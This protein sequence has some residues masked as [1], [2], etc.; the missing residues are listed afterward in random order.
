[1]KNL[2]N[3]YSVEDLD[4]LPI[5]LLSFKIQKKAYRTY[6]VRLYKR[7]DYENCLTKKGVSAYKLSDYIIKKYIGKLFDDAYSEYCKQVKWWQK[8]IFKSDFQEFN[9]KRWPQPYM[10][11]ENGL[12]QLNTNYKFSGYRS[13]YKNEYKGPYKFESSDIKYV[14]RHKITNDKKPEYS[15]FSGIY[16]K[17]IYYYKMK[18]KFNKTYFAKDSDFIPH[19]VQGW[20]KIFDSKNDPE[21]IRLMENKRKAIEKANRIKKKEKLKLTYSFITKDEIKKKEEKEINFYKIL[22]HGFDP[23]TSFRN[24]KSIVD[25]IKI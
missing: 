1:M 20:Y 5:E 12:I 9:T 4:I 14:L 18:N 23:T 21:Y 11:D 19:L 3:K 2:V 7:H 24:S 17:G 8:D 25:T 16:I 15:Y 22:S 13:P 6:F 10:I